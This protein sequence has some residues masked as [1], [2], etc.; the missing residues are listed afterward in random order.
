MPPNIRQIEGE[1]Q[2]RLSQARNVAKLGKDVF[3]ASHGSPKAALSLGK[4]FG[5]H[6]PILMTA[7]LFDLF[8]LIPFI[9]AVVNICFGAVMFMYFGKKR[10][11]PG[12]ILPIGILS[13][14]DF[15]FSLLPVNIA[16][17]V[18]RIALKETVG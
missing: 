2:G 9:S 15:I 5:K 11:I 12:V 3:L 6:W 7:V 18:I 10:I 4:K 1:R 13:V 8:A 16:T 14:F 17:V